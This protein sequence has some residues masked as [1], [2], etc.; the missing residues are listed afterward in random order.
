MSQ[1]SQLQICDILILRSNDCVAK[2]T[3]HKHPAKNVE[4]SPKHGSFQTSRKLEHE[5][6]FRPVIVP[7][8]RS[9]TGETRRAGE[10]A[11]E[12]AS[13]RARERE[14]ERERERERPRERESK[15]E[16]ETLSES[17]KESE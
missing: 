7:P 1:M 5:G 11:G 4:M 14:T 16:S 17:A 12:R 3:C 10:R 15:S 9:A 8:F 2:D 6:Q 13:E